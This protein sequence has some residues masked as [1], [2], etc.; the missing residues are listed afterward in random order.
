V[1][2]KKNLFNKYLQLLGV[3]AAKPTFELLRRIVKAH[4]IK[5][6]FENISKLIYKKQGMNYIPNLFT[7]LDGIENY[8]FGGTCYAN[9]HYLYSLLKH[10]GYDVKLCGADM[11]N[12]DVH[13]ISIVTIDGSEYIVDGGYAAPFFEPLPRDLNKDFV[14]N[15][16]DEK[17]LVKPKDESGRTKV[18]QY[19][20]GNLQH[21]YTVKPQ[22]RKIDDFRKVIKDSYADDAVFMNA[23]RITKFSETGSLV[24]R[25]LQLTELIGLK[26]LVS[27]IPLENI[28]EVVQDKFGMPAEKV[29]EVVIRIKKLKNIFD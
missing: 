25:N 7:Y 9:N 24:L 16:G 15:F 13:L 14:I 23:V 8:N 2:N 21:W 18:E 6:P 19:Y 22:E 4:L 10:L 29:S 1:I 3:K 28:P 17:Y 12:P 26:T 27:E 5:I 11:K 20:D